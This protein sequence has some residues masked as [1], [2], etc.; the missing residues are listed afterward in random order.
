MEIIAGKN[1]YE[2]VIKEN[3][4]K[5]SFDFSKVYWNSRLGTE[6]QRICDVIK[7]N[8][9][10]CDLM[11]GVGPFAIPL[12]KHKK[13]IVF[14]ILYVKYVSRSVSYSISIP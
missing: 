4:C 13:C 5:Y 14:I 9:T 8:E 1:K 7:E 2:T 12:A 6:H 3:G 10:I 11:S